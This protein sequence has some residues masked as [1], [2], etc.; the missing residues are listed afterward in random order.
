[1]TQTETADREAVQVRIVLVRSEQPRNVGA[2]VRAAANFGAEGVWIVAPGKWDQDSEREARVASSGAW[3]I[4]GGVH[5]VATLDE[6]VAD[7]HCVAGTSGR[8]RANAGAAETPESFFAR[9]KERTGS[10]RTALV[11]GPESQ[12]LSTTELAACHC[13]LRIPTQEA[14][15]SLNLGHAAAIL[16]YEATRGRSQPPEIR[17]DPPAAVEKQ[18]L[19][20]RRVSVAL[21]DTAGSDTRILPQLRRLLARCSPTEGDIALLHN[22]LKHFGPK[23]DRRLKEMNEP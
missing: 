8:K 14:F 22:L 16:L 20:L 17:K 21:A 1:M 3:E 2:V 19:W 9:L 10:Y 13:V 7:C 11:L 12:G 15:S 4:L 6:A 23:R 5:V 18:E